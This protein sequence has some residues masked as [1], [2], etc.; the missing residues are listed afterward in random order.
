MYNLHQLYFQH[1]IQT[2]IRSWQRE[3]VTD[4]RGGGGG[5]PYLH[6]VGLS[7]STL[8][9][10][11]VV[12]HAWAVWMWTPWTWTTLAPSGRSERWVSPLGGGTHRRPSWAPPAWGWRSGPWAAP[13]ACGPP[14]S[15]ACPRCCARWCT[16]CGRPRRSP[17]RC[18][19]RC[20]PWCAETKERERADW[21]QAETDLFGFD[22]LYNYWF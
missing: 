20:C 1:M 14:R 10:N 2:S 8:K 15:A 3:Q 9:S 18:P 17:S 4:G 22:C 21:M 13:S 7:P 11:W 16:R 12:R 19:P 6:L 5:V